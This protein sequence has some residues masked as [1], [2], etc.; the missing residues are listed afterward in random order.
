MAELRETFPRSE[1]TSLECEYQNLLGLHV[2]QRH[3]KVGY[4]DLLTN[5]T[6]LK[7]TVSYR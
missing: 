7:K 4:A 6:L 1:E 3:L 2:D 5:C